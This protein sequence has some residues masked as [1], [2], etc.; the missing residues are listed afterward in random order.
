M[1]HEDSRASSKHAKRSDKGNEPET[2]VGAE[3]THGTGAAPVDPNASDTTR[4]REHVSG[5]GGHGGEPKTSSDQR[6]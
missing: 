3:A 4:D 1:T 6:E 2:G 5:Y